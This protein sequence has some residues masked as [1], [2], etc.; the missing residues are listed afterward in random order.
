MVDIEAS[1]DDPRAMP[2]AHLMPLDEVFSHLGHALVFPENKTEIKIVENFKT[3]Q[4]NAL[5]EL[6]VRQNNATTCTT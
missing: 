5:Y 1:F 2:E 4:L 3:M 6:H